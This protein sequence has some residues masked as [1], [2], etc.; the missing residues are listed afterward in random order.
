MMGVA[1]RKIF[2]ALILMI[3]TTASAWAGDLEDSLAAYD[4]GDY[5][6]AISGFESVAEQGNAE[7]QYRLGQIYRKGEGVSPDYSKADSWYRRAAEQGDN[8]AQLN[9]GLMYNLGQGIP[10]DYAEATRWLRLAA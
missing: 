7:A 2:V 9:L 5:A 6:E 3:S 10:Q 8:R 1:V 4:A